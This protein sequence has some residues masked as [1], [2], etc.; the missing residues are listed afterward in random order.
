MATFISENYV[1]NEISNLLNTKNSINTIVHTNEGFEILFTKSQTNQK[2]IAA[3]LSKHFS[4][5]EIKGRKNPRILVNRVSMKT[6]KF[7][8][9]EVVY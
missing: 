4:H 3:E 7:K 2:E 1:R 5:V 6:I 8:V 9:V